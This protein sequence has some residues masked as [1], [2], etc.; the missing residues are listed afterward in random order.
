MIGDDA[1]PTGNTT[2]GDAPANDAPAND[3]A[4]PRLPRRSAML[5]VVG[6][7]VLA[8]AAV[9]ALWSWIAP[10]A[11]RAVVLTKAGDRVK[12]YV[13]D[14]ADHVFLA[15]AIMVGLLAVLGAAAGTAV[16]KW[17]A[18][19]GP[20]M[21]AALTLGLLSAAGGATGVGAALARVR[22]GV[23]D[24]AAAPV[25]PEHRVHYVTEAPGVFFGHS[26]WQIAATIAV[27]V[28]VGAFAYAFG[29]LSTSRDDLSAYPPAPA[30]R[31]TGPAPTAVAVPP[32]DPSRPAP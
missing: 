10:S 3:V 22:Y 25:T 28:G 1:R 4:P 7:L 29:A 5:R 21:L 11:Q 17:R 9:G 15:A 13:G 31:F 8:G 6:S 12:G 27:P 16:W 26:P 2:A 30:V 32:G 19:R 23:V 20:Q 18:H 24:V 14:E